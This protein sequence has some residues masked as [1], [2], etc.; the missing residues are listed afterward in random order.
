M[1][2]YAAVVLGRW[3]GASDGR[4]GQAGAMRERVLTAVADASPR[5]LA[6]L[7]PE[8]PVVALLAADLP[9]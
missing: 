9:C 4:A 7:D 5:I 3:G 2:A 6:L 1:T 8:V